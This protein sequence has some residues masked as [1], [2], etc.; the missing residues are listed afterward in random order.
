MKIV[1]FIM[2]GV[3]VAMLATL[4]VGVW[5]QAPQAY[6]PGELD[7]LLGPIALYTDPLIAQILPA[8]TFPDQLNQ[9]QGLMGING[10]MDIIDS[11]PWDVSVKAV[12]HYP[13]VLRMM[14]SKPDWTVAIGQ[15]YVNQPDDVMAS[16]QRLRA[17]AESMG[18][19]VDNPYQRCYL[20]NGYWRIVP[21]TPGYIYVPTY[22]PGVVYTRRYSGVGFDTVF[23]FGAGLAIGAW[24]NRDIG[25]GGRGVYYTGWRG[26]GWIAQNRS[27]VNFHNTY[28]VNDRYARGPV[29][30]NRNVNTM[31]IRDYRTAVRRS[32]A[33]GRYTPPQSVTRAGRIPASHAGTGV[34]RVK[35]IGNQ[36]RTTVSGVRNSNRTGTQG[37]RISPFANGTPVLRG[38]STGATH[39]AP[40]SGKSHIFQRPN[41]TPSSGQSRTFQRSNSTPVSTGKHTGSFGPNQSSS[42]RT[43]PSSGFQ[44]SSP[45]SGG[46]ARPA[47]SPKHS[48]APSTSKGE[49]DRNR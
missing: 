17:R 43:S 3:L 45:R 14:T 47:A 13:S 46:S 34:G 10:S 25:W 19:F 4:A 18:Y 33:G 5:A 16:I 41:S 38:S 27:R 29:Y 48:N 9:A 23:A 32:A 39:N 6:S 21:V 7:N 22:D 30:V 1:R 40:S 28:Y 44:K 11:Q 20:D 2:T 49:G 24:L 36:P 15:A 26:G 12:A 42:P 37:G 35:S 31:N 8:A